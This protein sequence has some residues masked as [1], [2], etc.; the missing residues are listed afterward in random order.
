MAV[1]YPRAQIRIYA[2]IDPVFNSIILK[3]VFI[4]ASGRLQTRRRSAWLVWSDLTGSDRPISRP[5]CVGVWMGTFIFGR[6]SQRAINL[7]RW[8]Q[9]PKAEIFG[10]CTLFSTEASGWGQF[11]LNLSGT[12]RNPRTGPF[13]TRGKKKKTERREVG[14]E[15]R[16]V[17][18]AD[19]LRTMEKGN[20]RWV[21]V[22]RRLL[23]YRMLL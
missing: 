18:L 5:E 17:G 3:D 1:R 15:K 21:W 2:H 14:R 13:R 20:N 23:K 4:T 9:T 19:H 8:S 16:L 10:P 12:Q 6:R 11:D 22:K 7:T